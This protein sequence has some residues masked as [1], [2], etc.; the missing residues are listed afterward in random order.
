MG[1]SDT[2]RARALLAEAAGFQLE[3]PEQ[4]AIDQ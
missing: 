1:H 2:E 4:E 3:M